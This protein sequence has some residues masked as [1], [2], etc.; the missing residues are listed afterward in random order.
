MLEKSISEDEGSG[1][2]E[3]RVSCRARGMMIGNA[4]ICR[5]WSRV[6]PAPM[7]A[8]RST[9]ER[10]TYRRKR[11]VIREQVAGPSVAGDAAL[12]MAW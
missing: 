10:V 3:T 8:F 12:G 1:V 4:R 2:S 9:G 5:A 7:R 6:N 11:S